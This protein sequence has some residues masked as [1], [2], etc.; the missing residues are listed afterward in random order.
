MEEQ[1]VAAFTTQENWGQ[2]LLQFQGN[3]GLTSHKRLHGASNIAQSFC[4]HPQTG[5]EGDWES[6]GSQ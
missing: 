2:L 4:L 6:G 3:R 1:E 5:V